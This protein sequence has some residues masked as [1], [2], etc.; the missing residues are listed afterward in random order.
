MKRL[1][2][3]SEKHGYCCAFDK[4][5]VFLYGERGLALNY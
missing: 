3:T 5:D 2:N 1:C 4:K